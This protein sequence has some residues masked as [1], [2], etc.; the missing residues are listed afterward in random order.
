MSLKKI[1]DHIYASLEFTSQPASAQLNY[2]Q[3]P[4][5]YTDLAKHMIA[6]AVDSG[7]IKKPPL[8]LQ[9]S[10]TIADADGVVVFSIDGRYYIFDEEIDDL[11]RLARWPLVRCAS[12][13]RHFEQ[14]EMPAMLLGTWKAQ[15]A[16]QAPIRVLSAIDEYSFR[17]DGALV[18]FDPMFGDTDERR[19]DV[20]RDDDLL[21]VKFT[22]SE[23][24][25]IC[26][27]SL[28]DTVMRVVYMD[29]DKVDRDDWFEFEKVSPSKGS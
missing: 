21:I 14:I 9:R 23:A 29:G 16:H 25:S 8:D 1:P 18:V 22:D 20:F 10:K 15:K 2:N 4:I 6:L 5:S 27:T 24:D 13:S 28:S 17:E 3:T 11:G 12:N 26:L 19:F 7:A